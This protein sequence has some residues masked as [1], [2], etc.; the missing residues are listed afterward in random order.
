MADFNPNYYCPITSELFVDPVI[1][2]DGNTFER[3]AIMEW[4]N[5]QGTSPITRNSLRA[6]DLVP[7]RVLAAAIESERSSLP[8]RHPE[9]NFES[10]E[11]NDIQH[12]ATIGAPPA[13]VQ[14]TR[15]LKVEDALR[16]LDQV[17]ASAIFIIPL[18]HSRPTQ[19][20]FPF[21]LTNLLYRILF[22]LN[23][24]SSCFF[25]YQHISSNR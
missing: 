4:I 9:V 2:C 12:R 24:N 7:N 23:S 14:D 25:T 13:T 10:R 21:T 17:R 19:L 20:Y 22:I 15:E 3:A 1:D 8:A 5:V 11:G 16:Y 18:P 6:E